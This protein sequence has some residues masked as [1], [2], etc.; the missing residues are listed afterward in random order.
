MASQDSINMGATWDEKLPASLRFMVTKTTKGRLGLI[1][2]Q[3][4]F[5][6]SGVQKDGS[7]IFR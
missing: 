1:I 5:R 7:L 2:G 6:K 3:Y 4:K